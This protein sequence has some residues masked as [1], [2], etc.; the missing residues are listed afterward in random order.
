MVQRWI[1]ESE[2]TWAVAVA[3]GI[4]NGLSVSCVVPYTWKDK[5]KLSVATGKPI[6]ESAEG[7]GDMTCIVRFSLLRRSFVHYRELSIG[8]GLKIPTGPTDRR[9]GGWLLSEEMQPGTG[10]WDYHGSVSYY[11]GFELVDFVISGTYVITTEHDGYEFGNQFLYLLA[12]DFHVT[13]RLSLSPALSGIVRAIDRDLGEEQRWTARHQLWF[14]P[15]VKFQAI[16][17][18]LGLQ[19]YLEYPIYQHF[20]GEQLGGDFNFRLTA[21]YSLPLKK[22]DEDD[23]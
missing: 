18:V 6:E 15:G 17:G 16:P 9:V 12:S 19:A 7:I 22:S 10:S 1:L 4:F 8:L 23:E 21:T 20:N 3:Y 5:S 11:Q 13:E 14:V 2:V